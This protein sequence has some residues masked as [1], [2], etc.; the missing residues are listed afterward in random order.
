MSVKVEVVNKSNHRLPEYACI[1]DAGM[2]VKA[3]ISEPIVLHSL[4]RVLIPTG[5]YMAIPAGYEIQVR[6]RSGAALKLGL[7]CANAVGTIDAKYRNEV[8][9]IAI[10][11]SREDIII[12]PG[13]RV[14]QFVLKKV[15]ECE[16]VEVASLDMTDD[17]G[18]GF[19][20]T[21]KN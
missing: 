13:D 3:N 1:G 12:N 16:W 18:G 9:V 21:G 5:L 4:D 10:N 17:R 7:S 2:D 15:E 8:G 20:H 6:P 14:A 19:G 11:L